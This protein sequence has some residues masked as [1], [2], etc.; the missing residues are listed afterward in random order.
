[1]SLTG[2]SHP[3]AT[4]VVGVVAHERLTEPRVIIEGLLAK[5]PAF[6]GP[7]GIL[8]IWYL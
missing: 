2:K 8:F 3:I 5:H 1:M 4:R 7:N 6:L